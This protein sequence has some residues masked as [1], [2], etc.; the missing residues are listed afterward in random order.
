MSD[1]NTGLSMTPVPSEDEMTSIRQI[2]ERAATAI[3]QAS[4]LAKQVAELQAQFNSLRNDME[5]LR[6]RNQ[7][8]DTALADVRTQ[9]D[10]AM[11]ERDEVKDK[12][13]S[14]EMALSQANDTNAQ[15]AAT[16]Q[17]LR[18]EL[19]MVSADRDQAYDAWHKAELS[20]DEAKSKLAKVQSALG[21]VDP[22]KPVEAPQPVVEPPQPATEP[23]VQ[24]D[25]QAF[26]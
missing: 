21:I 8:L 6:Q 17:R 11:R 18:D 9:R 14:F 16:I 4:E 10:T 5:Y 13:H 15:Q 24:A 19:A 2:F 7:E 25:P 3:V 1:G 23:V 20:A 12:A 26:P 22:P